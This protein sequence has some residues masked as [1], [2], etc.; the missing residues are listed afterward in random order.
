MRRRQLWAFKELSGAVVIEP[1]FFGLKAHNNRVAGGFTMIGC[2]LARRVIAAANVSA[3]STAP[4]VQPPAVRCHTLGTTGATWFR[5]W[6]DAVYLRPHVT[7]ECPHQSSAE[8]VRPV[9]VTKLRHMAYFR[10]LARPVLPASVAPRP[11]SP[12]GRRNLSWR[13]DPYGEIEALC[14]S[15]SQFDRLGVMSL[16]LHF[17]PSRRV[18]IYHSCR[19]RDKGGRARRLPFSG[20]SQFGAVSS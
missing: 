3:F 12:K 17:P 20:G 10:C 16:N 1:A 14:P 19:T 18:T 13:R 15:Q 6:I 11:R 7:E 4:Q 8:E 2:M 5:L 9:P